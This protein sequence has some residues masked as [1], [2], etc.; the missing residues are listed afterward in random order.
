MKMLTK[1]DIK[2]IRKDRLADEAFWDKLRRE[3]RADLAKF[4]FHSE[5]LEFKESTNKRFDEL[6]KNIMIVQ[7]LVIDT[8]PTL[9]EYMV[10]NDV[11]VDKTRRGWIELSLFWILRVNYYDQFT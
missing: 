4:T 11:K 10:L 3:R 1:E 5:F 2:A 9:K 6:L 8:N 7:D